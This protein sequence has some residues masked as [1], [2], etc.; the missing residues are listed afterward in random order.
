MQIDLDENVTVELTDANLGEAVELAVLTTDPVGSI[1]HRCPVACLST[2]KLRRFA[3]AVA[4]YATSVDAL[5]AY[6]RGNGEQHD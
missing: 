2:E 1:T 4:A 5:A 6:Y 3:K